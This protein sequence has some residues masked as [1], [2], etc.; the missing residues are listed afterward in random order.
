MRSFL[1]LV[2]VVTGTAHAAE[3]ESH[4]HSGAHMVSPASPPSPEGMIPS[5]A[6]ATTWINTA[7][8][9]PQEL[10][11]KVVLI[12]FWTYTCINWRR[13]VPS[14]RAWFERY[15]KSGL[16]LIGAHSPE[17][18]FEKDLDN[19]RQFTRDLGVEWPVAVDSDFSIWRAF[20]NE[21]WPALYIFDAKGRLRHQTFGEDGYDEA[22]RVIRQL[23]QEAGQPDP[24]SKPTTVDPRPF[25]KPADWKDLRSP[26]NYLGQ[27]RTVGFASPGGITAGKPHRY[28]VP[29]KM[30]LNRWALSGSWSVGPDRSVAA[31]AG[32]KIAY[33]FHARDLHLVMAPETR[34]NTIRF[35][36][37]LDGK[38]PGSSHGLDVDAEGNGTLKDQRMYQLIRQPGTIQ[39]RTF[40]IEFLDLGA[41]AFSFTFG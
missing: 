1:A 20:G 17:F 19:V 14:L 39:D 41:G 2:V 32:A 10:R 34:G 28:E 26:E 16:L 8:I 5:L 3:Q 24:G 27:Q 9:P 15:R 38:P 4:G 33:R 6:G 30:S 40:E 37:L 25:E 18:P 22:E 11:G 35:R 12:D 36:V 23:L 29:S 7:P 13:T 21:Y 31:A